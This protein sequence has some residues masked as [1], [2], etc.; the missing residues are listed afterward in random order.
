M[1]IKELYEWSEKNGVENKDIMVVTRFG[2]GEFDI[3]ID[4][5]QLKNLFVNN[6]GV[7]VDFDQLGEFMVRS[8]PSFQSFYNII[9]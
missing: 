4:K 5:I 3:R 8:P 6:A 7:C 9:F 2:N 1:T